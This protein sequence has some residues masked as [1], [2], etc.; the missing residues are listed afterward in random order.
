MMKILSWNVNG[1]QSRL[2]AV[3]R[4]V[5]ELQ[6]DLMCLQK[7]RKKG[8]FITSIPGYMGWLGSMNSGLF[9]GVSTYIHRGLHFEFEDQRNDTPEWLRDTGCLNVIRFDR[10][11]LVNAYF[12]YVDL[13]NEQYVKDRQRWNYELHDYLVRL[14]NQKPVILC[15]DLNIVNEDLDAWDGVS[16]A[17]RG[18][19]T[20]WEHRDFNLLLAQTGLVDTYRYL[21]P[22]GNDYSYF[23]QN[24]P[25]YR[26]LNQGF[27]IDYCMMSEELLPYLT[28]SEI[29]TDITATANS[30]LLIEVDLPKF[31]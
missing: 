15:G 13:S 22:D 23:F 20:E 25:E 30:P 5:T 26:L 16:V 21:H 9:G 6:P 3:N 11:I 27:R 18:C 31:L 4:L 8:D 19:F 17:K 7:V 1:V 24:K 28:K 2:E 14:T 29:L 10:F 12:P